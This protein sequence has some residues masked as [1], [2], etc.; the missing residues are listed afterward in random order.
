MMELWRIV[1]NPIFIKESRTETSKQWLNEELKSIL[2]GDFT[3][4][5]PNDIRTMNRLRVD[6]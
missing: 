5:T 6:D 3:V 4:N 1:V 2:T